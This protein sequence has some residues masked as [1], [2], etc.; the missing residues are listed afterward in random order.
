MP[1][2]ADAVYEGGVLKLLEPLDL[3]ENEHVVVNVTRATEPEYGPGVDVEFMEQLRKKAE[4]RP[5]APS[6]KDV[7]KFTAKIPGNWSE[8]IVAEPPGTGHGIH[9]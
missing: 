9:R 3:E 5:P 7:R 6:L 4:G 8:D 1:M 2:R